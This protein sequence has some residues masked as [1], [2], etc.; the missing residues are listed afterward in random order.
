MVCS[1]LYIFHSHKYY[2]NLL[3]S[4]ERHLSKSK[5]RDED[6]VTG[7]PLDTPANPSTLKTDIYIYKIEI[8]MCVCIYVMISQTLFNIKYLTAFLKSTLGKAQFS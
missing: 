1:D 7:G 4:S 2:L 3:K 8:C 5:R 6:K